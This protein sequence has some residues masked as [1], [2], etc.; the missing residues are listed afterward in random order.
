MESRWRFQFENVQWQ[1]PYSPKS[2]LASVV[3]MGAQQT[4]SFSADSA[5]Q[6]SSSI[7]A[8]YCGAANEVTLAGEQYYISFWLDVAA[9]WSPIEA[10]WLKRAACAFLGVFTPCFLFY[11]YFDI[12]TYN[13]ALGP[14]P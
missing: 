9:T 12:V 6:A 10:T 7:L 4:L 13:S 2:L 11:R 8:G 5:P 1:A 3:D 14:P